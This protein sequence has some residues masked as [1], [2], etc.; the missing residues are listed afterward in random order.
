MSIKIKVKDDSMEGIGG[1]KEIPKTK[2]RLDIRKTLDGNYIIQDHPYIDIILSPSKS[3]ILALSTIAMD[4][5][6]YY[7][8]NKYFDFLYKRGVIDPS[9]VQAGNIYASMEAA[10]PQTQEKVDPIEVIIFTTAMFM[11]N[12]RPSFEYEKAMRKAQDDYLT[13][14]TEEDSTELGEV[15]QKARQ[16]SIGTAAYSINKNYNIAYLGER[17]NKK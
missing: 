13:D 10:I 11:D 8:Q 7:T 12:E 14:P 17:K 2:V 9:T 15:P 3:K 16:G 6:V 5:K 1:E 4:D